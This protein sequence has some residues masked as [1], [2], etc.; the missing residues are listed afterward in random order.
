MA[1]TKP[2][3]RSGFN[4]SSIVPIGNT[5]EPWNV[6]L[7]GAQVSPDANGNLTPVNL[8][9]PDRGMPPVPTTADTAERLGGPPNG[10]NV[11]PVQDITG[12][13]AIPQRPGFMPALGRALLKIAPIAGQLLE[14]AAQ[15]QQSPNF[16]AAAGN[17]FHNKRME[18][19]MEMAQY[20][21]A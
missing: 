13:P 10:A 5:P 11:T 21:K 1:L 12:P 3:P 17:V 9:P 16:L 4:L 2:K 14:G 18:P 15:G 8:P 7:P 20:A 19:L 6:P